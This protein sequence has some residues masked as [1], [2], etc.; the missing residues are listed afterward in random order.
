MG[1]SL[2]EFWHT[3]TLLTLFFNGRS[4]WEKGFIETPNKQSPDHELMIEMSRYN[5]NQTTKDNKVLPSSWIPTNRRRAK[6]T[7]LILPSG[8]FRFF[9]ENG[10][11]DLW[12][13]SPKKN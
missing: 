12:A 13:D 8:P 2:C 11:I 5:Y 10:A 4:S 7:T 9:S 6:E 3:N 1:M